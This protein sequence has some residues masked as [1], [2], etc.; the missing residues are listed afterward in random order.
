MQSVTELIQLSQTGDKAA[1]DSLY[2]MIYSDLHRIA[3]RHLRSNAPTRM[4]TTSL[5]N[6]T[7]LRLAQAEALSIRDRAHLLATSSRIMRQ[8]I[9]S[10][11]RAASAHKRGG[12]EQPIAFDTKAQAA[13]SESQDYES[14]L[15]LDA[16]LV[17]LGQVSPRMAE[18]VQLRFFGGLELSEI[19]PILGVTER[20]LKRDWRTARAFLYDQL[21]DHAS[22]V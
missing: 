6:E 14:V 9:I 5:V 21:K 11:A 18:L 4:Q 12:A 15:A 2:Q 16:A 7:Y 17:Q 20:T 13:I 1:E 3:Q 10:H 8:I 22:I 19:E